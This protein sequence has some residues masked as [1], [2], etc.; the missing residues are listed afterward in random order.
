M[1]RPIWSGSISFGLLNIPVILHSAENKTDLK[2]HLLDSRDKSRVKYVR[3]NEE[4]G[5]EV[6]WGEIVKGYNYDDGKYVLLDDKDFKQAA[7]EA[8]KSIELIAFVDRDAISYVY[9]ETPYY[10]VPAKSG[11]KGYVLLREVLRRTEKVGVAKVVIRTRQYLA[12]VLSQDNAL[13]LDLIRFQQELRETSELDIPSNDLK[14]Y[15]VTKQELDIAAQLVDSLSAKWNPTEY[16]DDYRDALMKF[17]RQKITKGG[18][19]VAAVAEEPEEEGRG[20]VIDMMALLK[21][22]V[23]Q[24]GKPARGK[25]ARVET[26][27]SA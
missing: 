16:H 6:P 11:E 9:F 19:A 3:I 5:E 25:P 17:I 15:K 21:E 1:S 14:K 2:F 18:K 12:V 20:K 13:V 7:P 24:K 4:T 10:L 23:K 27:K 8:V 22:S 26:R